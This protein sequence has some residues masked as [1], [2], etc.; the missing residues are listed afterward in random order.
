MVLW[1]SN[2]YVITFFLIATL[3]IH[4][5]SAESTGTLTVEDYNSGEENTENPLLSITGG[6]FNQKICA[7]DSSWPD[8][9][10]E[11]PMPLTSNKMNLQS[12]DE[13][14]NLT[15]FTRF[16][17]IPLDTDGE[18]WTSVYGSEHWNGGT[19]SLYAKTNDEKK[20]DEWAGRYL[21][22]Q[23]SDSGS[24]NTNFMIIWPTDYEEYS[25]GDWPKDVGSYSAILILEI[26]KTDT[27]S[28]WNRNN[29]YLQTLHY[30]MGTVE[31]ISQ[32]ESCFPPEQMS[33]LEILEMLICGTTSCFILLFLFALFT[34]PKETF[35]L[36]SLVVGKINGKYNQTYKISTPTKSETKRSRYISNSV[37]GEV[38]AR[39]DGRCVICQSTESL[40]FDHIIP[41]S[42]GGS[43]T[44]ENLQ[45]LCDDCNQK[46]SNKI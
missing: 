16:K 6:G 21:K 25:D 34:N 44:S 8:I 24:F 4:N 27:Q 33:F 11:I 18:N 10:S 40:Q 17:F 46:R 5:V 26:D 39:D 28:D 30:G 41:F 3:L 20:D 32:G 38:W 43:N 9:E 35:T 13:E 36:I 14:R 1:I 29:D 2:K 12:L 42:K 19:N 37:R 23:K 31:V 15:I 45:L 22:F 7:A